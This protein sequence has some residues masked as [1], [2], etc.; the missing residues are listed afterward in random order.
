MDGFAVQAEDLR[1][2]SQEH[3][4]SLHVI[5]EITAGENDPIELGS[6]QAVRIMTGGPIPPGCDAVVPVEQTKYFPPKPASDGQ[7]MVAIYRSVQSG[8]YIRPRGEDVNA[9]NLV[10]RAG[11]RLRPQDI[12][13]LAMLGIGTISVHR[14]PRIAVFS[15]GDELLRVGRI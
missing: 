1:R 11:S 12:G 13:F 3:P 14:P 9:D 6:G 2:A 8:D 7:A 5:G 15:S 10:L 4:V